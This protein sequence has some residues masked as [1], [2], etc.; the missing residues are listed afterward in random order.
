MAERWN[1]TVRN[2]MEGF[3]A[4][5]VLDLLTPGADGEGFFEA[6]VQGKKLG[7][8]DV[9]HDARSYEQMVAGQMLQRNNQAYWNTWTSFTNRTHRERT[10]PVEQEVL[11]YKID[12]T[13]DPSLSLHCVTRIRVKATADSR[14][15]I[16]F[17]LSGQMRALSAKV[18]GVPAE[19]YER[20]SILN[21]RV[22]GNG[23]ELL[24]IIPPKPLEPG[25][26]YEIEVVHEGK[27][28]LEAGHDVYYVSSRG[29]WYPS[30]GLQFA[31]YDVTWHYPASLS[32]VAA[33]EVVED[34]I[35]ADVH[36]TRRVPDGRVRT[37]GFNLGHY[38]LRTVKR[39]GIS[40]ELA[41]NQEVED[42]LQP[43]PIVTNDLPIPDNRRRRPGTES[44]PPPVFIPPKP[45]PPRVS[46]P[47]PKRSWTLPLSTGSALGSHR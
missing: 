24:L 11:T 34:S 27:V 44:I 31:R 40:V 22:E 20:D 12:A 15:A 16:A 28:I 33:G 38:V 18:D 45:V 23:N 41:A 4:R 6:V 25:H 47:S 29:T 30:R 14:A 46:T 17:D 3:E 10:I 35:E 8:F 5:I 32:L 7:T 2:L 21:G 43:K 26:E 19:V 36:T 39:D 42:A 1:G 9:V 37:M 13:I